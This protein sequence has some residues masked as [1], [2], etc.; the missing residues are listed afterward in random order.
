M[1]FTD[2]SV[3]PMDGADD[4]GPRLLSLDPARLSTTLPRSVPP[5]VSEKT[6]FQLSPPGANCMWAIGTGQCLLPPS[7]AG[8]RVCSG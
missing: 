3:G 7:S 1:A 4:S 5:G 2:H 8:S 6:S